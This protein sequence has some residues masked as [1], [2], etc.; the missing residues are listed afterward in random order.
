[1]STPTSFRATVSLGPILGCLAIAALVLPTSGAASGN[2]GD[3]S[4][5]RN[6]P[7]WEPGKV[8]LASG[9]GPLDTRS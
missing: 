5:Y 7:L 8:P 6:I 1:M 4:H 2:N 3:L 9:S